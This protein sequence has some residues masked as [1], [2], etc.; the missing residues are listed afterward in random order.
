MTK[1]N[2]ALAAVGG[3]ELAAVDVCRS[4]IEKLAELRDELNRVGCEVKAWPGGLPGE[5][6]TALQD[7]ATAIGLANERVSIA[8][9]KI[10]AAEFGRR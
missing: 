5:V 2:T 7:A 6:S 1:R 4:S 9:A 8:D 10:R 3:R